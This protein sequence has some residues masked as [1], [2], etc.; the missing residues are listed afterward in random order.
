M[1]DV[2]PGKG[3]TIGTSVSDAKWTAQLSTRAIGHPLP[4]TACARGGL[5]GAVT[6]CWKEEGSNLRGNSAKT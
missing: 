5:S 1:P 3:C 4:V 2:H 6:K